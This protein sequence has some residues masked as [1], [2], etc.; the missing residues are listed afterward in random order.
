MR[1]RTHALADIALTYLSIQTNSVDAERSF[2]VHDNIILDKRHKLTDENT[3]KLC[4]LYFNA[5]NGALHVL[6]RSFSIT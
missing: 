6:I 5:G 3:K 1:T 2:R 4:G